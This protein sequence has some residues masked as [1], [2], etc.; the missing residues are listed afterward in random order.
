[1]ILIVANIGT[2]VVLFPILKRQN[3]S[4][5][6]GY[7]TARVVE[8]VFIAVGILSLLA[9]V[10]LRQ[11][12]GARRR[13]LARHRR[14]V[15]RRDPR[16]DVP[17]R[18]RLGRRHRERAD[19]GLP[20]VPIR[21]RAAPHDLAGADRRPADHPV[22]DRSCCSTSS[23]RAPQ[24][25][26]SRRSRNSSGSCRSASTSSSRDSCRL[27]SFRTTRDPSSVVASRHTRCLR[28]G[29][30][31]AG[32]GA[33][34]FADRCSHE[35]ARDRSI[36]VTPSGRRVRCLG[37]GR[38]R[39]GTERVRRARDRGDARRP[40]RRDELDRHRR[41]LRQGR[42]G[43]DRGEGRPGPSGPSARVHQGGPGFGGNGIPTGP[44]AGGDPSLAAASRPGRRRPL[45]APLA[46]R[47]GNPG[48]G[49]V[50][51][52]GR[53][54]GRGARTPRRRLELRPGPHRAMRAGGARRLRAERVLPAGPGR[55]GGVPAVARRTGHR[56]PGLFADGRGHPHR[57]DAGRPRVPG[58]RLAKR[59]EDPERS[60][61]S[62]SARGPSRRTWRRR[63]GWASSPRT[64]GT[65][66]AGLALA[67][68][69][70][71][72]PNTVAIAG[73]RSAEHARSN[74]AAGDLDLE[75]DVLAQIDAIFG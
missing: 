8:S 57:R 31:L 66:T 12:V 14:P 62:C 56:V 63:I 23:S 21:A 48:G 37:G 40:R 27:R 61:R 75:P 6:L 13:G 18:A 51:R 60:I 50:G 52:D 47:D 73:S 11:D 67:W 35:D 20:D 59:A 29:Q 64:L 46:G 10:T 5:A 42:V 32:S 41:G 33:I 17:A 71:A 49:D 15:A 36:G 54:S 28:L 70:A 22:G 2:A 74:A 55:P 25:R 44:G 34:G 16:L 45:P 39:V 9:V 26:P 58:R 68:V 7:V 43:A 19:P 3:E 24:R 38:R 69:V 30:D 1:M 72:S 65:T 4:L 53:P